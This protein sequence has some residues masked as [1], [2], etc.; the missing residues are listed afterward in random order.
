MAIV[1]KDNLSTKDKSLTPSVSIVQ[2]FHYKHLC[3]CSYL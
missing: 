3:M 1:F 2:R